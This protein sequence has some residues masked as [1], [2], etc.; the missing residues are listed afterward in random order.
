L[1]FWQLDTL[2]PNFILDWGLE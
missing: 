1:F 2:T